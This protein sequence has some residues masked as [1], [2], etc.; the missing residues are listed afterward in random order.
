M[1]SKR[2]R[3]TNCTCPSPMAITR[4]GARAAGSPSRTVSR[5]VLIAGCALPR[6]GVQTGGGGEALRALPPG[7]RA[8]ME[9]Y[10]KTGVKAR[11]AQHRR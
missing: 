11:P 3:V 5:G 2:A 4:G 9:H 1:S 8:A 7:K 10:L 6:G